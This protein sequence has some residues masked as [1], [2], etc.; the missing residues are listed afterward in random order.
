MSPPPPPAP[1]SPT[2]LPAPPSH[3]HRRYCSSR[4]RCVAASRPQCRSLSEAQRSG[5]TRRD[6][7]A[8]S[9]GAS[10]TAVVVPCARRLVSSRRILTA[11]SVRDNAPQRIPRSRVH[12]DR[13][14][15][16]GS[17]ANCA[18][19]RGDT[20][21][22]V[23]RAVEEHHGGQRGDDG[24]S[25]ET[26]VAVGTTLQR[27]PRRVR[28]LPTRE[29]RVREPAAAAAATADTCR[30]LGRGK[31]WGLRRPTGDTRRRRPL[32]VRRAAAPPAGAVLTRGAIELLVCTRLHHPHFSTYSAG[33]FSLPND[34]AAATCGH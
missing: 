16:G 14:G 7:E 4:T 19:Q 26:G 27:I 20:R 32:R 28:R 33:P 23:H 30:C 13:C 10:A 8:S 17:S 9:A 21:S 6:D 24:P 22:A 5:R 11:D 12:G 15:E 18:T 3:H 2:L 25:G 34:T 31:R 1:L 29:S